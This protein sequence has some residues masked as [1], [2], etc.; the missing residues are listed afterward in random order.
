MKKIMLA[1]SVSLVLSGCGGSTPEESAS[2]GFVALQNN[3]YRVAGIEFKTALQKKPS[4]V[5]ARLGL[6]EMSVL[7]R[8]FDGALTELSKINENSITVDQSNKI[9]LLKARSYH[10]GEFSAILDLKETRND[11]INF[12]KVYEYLKRNDFAK[13]EK[14]SKE[15]GN[16]NFGELSRYIVETLEKTPEEKL[17]SLPSATGNDFY[18][19]E[20]ALLKLDFALDKKDPKIAIDTLEYYVSINPN[21]INR[22]FQL[23]NIQITTGDFKGSEKHLAKLLKAAPNSP[24]LHELNSIVS[25]EKE[26]YEAALKSTSIT[27]ANDPSAITPRLINS[28]IS[29]SRDD[30]Q[31]ALENLEFIIDDLPTSH[32]AQRLYIKLKAN[33]GDMDGVLERA[34]A[35]EDLTKS[36]LGLISSLGIDAIRSGNKE[37]AEKLAAKAESLGVSDSGLGLLQLSLNKTDLAFE[38]LEK[39][40]RED[41]TSEIAA[42]S[43]ATAYLAKGKY[44]EAL[45]LSKQWISDGKKVEGLM[46]KAVVESRRKDVKS[47]HKTFLDVLKLKEDHLMARSG[48]IETSVLMGDLEGARKNFDRWIE[49]PGQTVLFK[50]YI[51]TLKEGGEEREVDTVISS[52]KNKLSQGKIKDE[53][54]QLVLG[55]SYFVNSQPKEALKTV[56]PLY[57]KYKSISSFLLLYSSIAESLNDKASAK[58]AYEDWA[59]IDP[60]SPMPVLGVVKI[61]LSENKTEDAISYLESAMGNFEEKDPGMMI[62]SQI[63]LKNSDVSNF[64][65]TIHQVD[66]SVL[67]TN[68]LGSALLGVSR[69]ID[70]DLQEA[71]ELLT[72]YVKQ[73]GDPD[74][75]RWLIMSTVKTEG[76]GAVVELLSEQYANFPKNSSVGFM[77]GNAYASMSKFKEATDVYQKVLSNM[78]NPPAVLLNN[79]AAVM[80]ELSMSDEAEEHARSAVELEPTNPSYIDTLGS[81]LNSQGRYRETVELMTELVKTGVEVSEVF[82]STLDE[83]KSK[84]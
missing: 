13:A 72:P 54:A 53:D 81:I 6:A 27:L 41:S 28:Y 84:L 3:D 35:L 82:K 69:A 61:L 17:S 30:P 14:I 48:V 4:L 74:F 1:L 9:Q 5:S 15:S 83:A 76:P 59:E 40:W 56:E 20:K 24:K 79:L 75:V 19:S 66:D 55:Q 8:D 58:K 23:V 62:L 47:A 70:N 80:N 32:N 68:L 34:L 33:T 18:L 64:K 43:L 12:Y 21:D 52:F 39:N 42:N 51:S 73:T 26:D 49:E 71:K 65:K 25:F 60:T 63:H 78:P 46:L 50:N 37:G 11:E 22:L 10:R 38:N 16:T 77:L 45:V 67:K 44:D 29:V 7:S 2:K 31:T 57:G 36:D